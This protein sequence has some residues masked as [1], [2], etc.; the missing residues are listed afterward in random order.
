MA[1][2]YAKNYVGRS[3]PKMQ[4]GDVWVEESG[5]RWRVDAL[6]GWVRI[7]DVPKCDCGAKKA[8]T[9]HAHWCSAVEE[10]RKC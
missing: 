10:N 7:A 1:T 3:T 6:V 4:D 8:N 2:Y 9:S 5:V